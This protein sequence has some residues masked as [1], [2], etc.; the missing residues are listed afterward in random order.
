MDISEFTKD[1]KYSFVYFDKNGEEVKEKRASS[2]Y[3]RS[4]ENSQNKM[5]YVKFFRGKMFDPHGIDANRA[6]S[7]PSNES[8]FTG[9]YKKVGEESFNFY[10][11]YLRTRQR[12]NLTWA[13]R[14]YIDV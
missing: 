3:L 13:E 7:N 4:A 1:P 10:L 6:N 8:S 5:H 9:E 12:N 2:A 11:S 14:G